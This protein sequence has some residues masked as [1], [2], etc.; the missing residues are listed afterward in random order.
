MEDT[1]SNITHEGK[2]FGFRIN[3]PGMVVTERL[4]ETKLAQ[5]DEC[6]ECPEFANCYKL[7]L[8]T[9]VLELGVSHIPA[10]V[11]KVS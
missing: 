3:Q 10:R 6:T 7:S 2:A 8:A 1:R 4:V 11:G 5:W 9:L